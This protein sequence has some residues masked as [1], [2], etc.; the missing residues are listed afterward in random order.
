MAKSQ[1]HL[2]IDT[3]PLDVTFTVARKRFVAPDGTAYP[4]AGANVF[5]VALFAGVTGD[6]IDMVIS[7]IAVVEA[8]GTIAVGDHLTAD[9]SGRVVAA[10]ALVVAAGATPVTSSAANG[11]I[12]TGGITPQVI[13]G[14]ALT[15]GA[16]GDDI[17]VLLK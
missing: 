13:V 15:A 17:L 6:T 1:G 8:G 2:R 4:A 16:T 10:A 12:L 7:G 9:S 3:Y 5:G 11:A 14:K